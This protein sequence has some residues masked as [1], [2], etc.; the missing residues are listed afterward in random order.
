[1]RSLMYAADEQQYDANLVKFRADWSIQQ[2]FLQYFDRYWTGEQMQR[3]WAMC[4]QPEMYTNMATNNYVESW[5]GALKTRFLERRRNKRLDALARLLTK[6]VEESV[7]ERVEQ[8]AAKVGRIGPVMRERRERED[9]ASK[10]ESV[11]IHQM[12]EAVNGGFTVRSFESN[13]VFYNVTCF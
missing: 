3:R 9:E 12:V 5:H 1:L 8:L 7:V 11:E 13:D 6:K 4:F 10:I 2:Q